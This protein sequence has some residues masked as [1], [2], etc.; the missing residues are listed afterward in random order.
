MKADVAADLVPK[1]SEALLYCPLTAM[2][3]RYYRYVITRDADKLAAATNASKNSL[4]NS[5][6]ISLHFS[7]IYTPLHMQKALLSLFHRSRRGYMRIYARCR[8]TNASKQQKLSTS[9][10]VLF[11]MHMHMLACS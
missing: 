2:Q 7:H 3:K 1:K 8:A 10:Y 4:L 6:Y 11:R 9:V 5:A